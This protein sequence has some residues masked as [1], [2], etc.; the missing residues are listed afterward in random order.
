MMATE[1]GVWLKKMDDVAETCRRNHYVT[2]I[3]KCPKCHEAVRKQID[4]QRGDYGKA[5][6][7]TK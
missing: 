1:D 5:R 7:E 3:E 4:F 2:F 6:T